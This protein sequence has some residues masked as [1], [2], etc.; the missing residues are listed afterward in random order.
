MEKIDIRL[1]AD[2]APMGPLQ[3]WAVFLCG[4]ILLIDGYDLT[5]I[6]VALPSLMVDLKIEASA[7]GVLASAALGGMMLG[8]MVLGT[9][10]ER[11]GRV[12]AIAI[13]V[14]IFS[15]F[16]MACGLA[17]D[18][19]TFGM[20]RFV[21]GLGLGGVLPAVTATITEFAPQRLRSFITTGVFAAYSVGS[22]L[23]ALLGRFLLESLGWQGVFY[24]AGLP[25]LLIPVLLKYLPE[26]A[27]V[28]QSRH[29]SKSLRE[30]A[31]RIVPSL[32]LAASAEV[33]A[34]MPEKKSKV[35]VGGLFQEG[36]AFSTLMLWIGFFSGLFMFYAL[37]SWLTKLMAM[38][39]YSLKSALMF[40]LLLNCGAAMGS[41][42][43]GWV[44][45][46]LGIKR[47]LTSMLVFGA[48]ATALLAQSMPQ[49]AIAVL[50]FIV[51]FTM[52]G[53]QGLAYAYVGQFYPAS[54]SSTGVGMSAGVGRI[55]GIAAPIIIGTLISLQLPHAQ[56]FYVI[57]TFGLL[58]A[59][60][61]ALINNRVAAFCQA[62]E[63]AA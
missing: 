36:R 58:Q 47:V 34:P 23:A 57:A 52:V 63:V 4:L 26:S 13:S 11:I 42:C 37:N 32:Q 38:A 24:L 21:A 39:G 31:L 2:S 12:K 56:N 54:V 5:V 1:L 43:S 35:P 44:A 50:V 40:L 29:D 33:Y 45:D 62:R 20:L 46:R 51:G 8:A 10:A 14:F 18:V 48:L 25:V 53:G 61:F 49:E 22:I 55:G 28:L 15:F 6:G 41:F 16:T 59:V 27:A 7:A 9:L 19:W 60:A 17:N 3:R 30:L